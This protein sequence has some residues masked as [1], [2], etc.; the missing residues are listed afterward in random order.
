MRKIGDLL[1]FNSEIT[2]DGGQ[3]LKGQKYIL[4]SE[5]MYQTEPTT[6][7]LKTAGNHIP[8]IETPPDYDPDAEFTWP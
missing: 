5:V 7:S 4:R 3:I 6:S 1:V 2:H 8:S